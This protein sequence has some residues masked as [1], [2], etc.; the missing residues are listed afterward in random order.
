MTKFVVIDEEGFTSCD[1]AG[2]EPEGFNN[3]DLAK[4]RADEL[5][6]GSPGEHIGIY[7]MFYYVIAS[8]GEVKLVEAP[9]PPLI[10]DEVPTAAPY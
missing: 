3:F 1:E 2:E 7:E 5:A 10:W 4:K 6:L 9:S 8:H